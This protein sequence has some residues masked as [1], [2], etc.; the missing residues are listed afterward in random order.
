[1]QLQRYFEPLGFVN[2]ACT[3]Q[4]KFSVTDHYRPFRLLQ[5]TTWSFKEEEISCDVRKSIFSFRRRFARSQL[6][7]SCTASFYAVPSFRG[8]AF[9]GCGWCSLVTESRRGLPPEFRLNE[10]NY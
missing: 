3:Q 4:V 9:K 7:I 8:F 2:A 1:M 10:C 5:F 6:A